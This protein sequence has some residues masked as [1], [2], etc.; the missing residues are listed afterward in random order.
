ML[1]VPYT[2]RPNV[3]RQ[4]RHTDADVL[5]HGVLLCLCRY[6]PIRSLIRRVAPQGRNLEGSLSTPRN[7]GIRTILALLIMPQSPNLVNPPRKTQ[8]ESRITNTRRDSAVY[9]AR[10]SL[11]RRPLGVPHRAGTHSPKATGH[12]RSP[13]TRV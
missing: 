5:H 7:W 11:A 2:S 9:S 3:C 4:Y 12:G 8:V 1:F 13:R 6:C 10:T